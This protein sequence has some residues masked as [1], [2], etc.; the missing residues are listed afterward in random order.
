MMLLSTFTSLQRGRAQTSAK[1]AHSFCRSTDTT[2]FNG[3][4]PK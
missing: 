1:G 3:A 2:R 4:A